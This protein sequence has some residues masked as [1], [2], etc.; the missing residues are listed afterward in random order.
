MKLPNVTGYKIEKA[1]S[2]LK[3]AGIGEC[4]VTETVPPGKTVS[5][6]NDELRVIRVKTDGKVAELLAGKT[7]E[8]RI[9]IS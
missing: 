9:D 8:S 3:K 2:V 1:I 6:E 7:A 5:G 4:S